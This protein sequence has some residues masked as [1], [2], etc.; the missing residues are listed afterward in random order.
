MTD[1][2]QARLDN[3]MFVTAQRKTLGLKP[4][5][6]S[7]REREEKGIAHVTVTI[8][9]MKICEHPR[10]RED[11]GGF[12][13][14]YA[15]WA[16]KRGLPPKGVTKCDCAPDVVTALEVQEGVRGAEL[17]LRA[18]IMGKRGCVDRIERYKLINGDI[19][20]RAFFRMTRPAD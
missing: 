20:V 12:K 18:D 5:K 2:E 10:Q 7:R 9:D 1:E 17:M 15:E 4:K 13:G 14:S 11:I 8:S 19:E 3:Q 6:Q 16:T